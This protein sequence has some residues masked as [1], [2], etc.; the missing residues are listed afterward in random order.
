MDT[1]APYP[2]RPSERPIPLWN[3]GRPRPMGQERRKD[4]GAPDRHAH[5][6]TGQAP[7]ESVQRRDSTRR[8][9]VER[10]I[11]LWLEADDTAREPQPGSLAHAA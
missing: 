3:A 7:P 10:A 11:R 8:R 6:E 5:A 9:T 4:T 2:P 1:N